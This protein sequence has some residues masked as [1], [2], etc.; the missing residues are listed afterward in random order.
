MTTV[1][2]PQVNPVDFSGTSVLLTET[3][4]VEN[5]VPEEEVWGEMEHAQDEQWHRLM[6][7]V[8]KVYEA[9]AAPEPG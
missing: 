9:E 4:H 7:Y 3:D 2:S 1:E 6:A 8:L 5:W